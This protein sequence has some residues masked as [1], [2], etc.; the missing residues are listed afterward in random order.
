VSKNSAPPS[1]LRKENSAP[2][3]A[4][5]EGTASFLQ[6]ERAF[7]F[8]EGHPTLFWRVFFHSLWRNPRSLR[9][10]MSIMALLPALWSLFEVCG[11]QDSQKNRTREQDSVPGRPAS[12]SGGSRCMTGHN[13]K[14]YSNIL[15]GTDAPGESAGGG[16]RTHTPL[17][18]PDF[19]SGASASSATP[20]L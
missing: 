9:Y 15:Q 8:R 11:W 19:E 16:D 12:S 18:V 13:S 3:E 5:V 14:K 17:R 7:G 20:A 1:I 2:D 6:N 10:T 4:I